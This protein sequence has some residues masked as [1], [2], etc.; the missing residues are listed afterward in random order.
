M[1]RASVKQ[2]GDFIDPGQSGLV[3]VGESNVKDAIK[4]AVTSAEK[5]TAEDLGVD[6]KETDHWPIASEFGRSRRLRSGRSWGDALHCARTPLDHLA[7]I[8]VLADGGQPTTQT[9]FPIF[10]N[11]V[12][13]SDLR[14]KVKGA[15]QQA[16]SDIL[17]LHPWRGGD[18]KLWL[19]HRLDIIDKHRLL[20]TV[21]NVHRTGQLGG[22]EWDVFGDGNLVPFP[23]INFRPPIGR[24]SAMAMSCS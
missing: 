21:A 4:N 7:Y 19:L 22:G 14:G 6:P 12:S 16:I 10:D 11:R 3:I 2:L 9:A 13:R 20:L 18:D 17:D 1:S 24:S 8:L 15:S 5:E 23:V